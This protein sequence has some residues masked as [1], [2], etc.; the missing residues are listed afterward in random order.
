MRARI[1][2]VVL[3]LTSI[4]SSLDAVIE[5]EIGFASMAFKVGTE[6]LATVMFANREARMPVAAFTG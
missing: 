4:S 1:G 2:F 5:V 3:P 6:P